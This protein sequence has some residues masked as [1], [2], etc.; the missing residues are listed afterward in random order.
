MELES[1]ECPATKLS[2]V[3]RAFIV[4]DRSPE[5]TEMEKYDEEVFAGYG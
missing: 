2:A 3:A 1:S 4:L 5:A